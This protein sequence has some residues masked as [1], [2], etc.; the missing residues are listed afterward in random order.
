MKGN[1][2]D[3]NPKDGIGIKKVPFSLIP[4]N[5]LG[6][7]GLS[8]LEGS[9]KYGSNNW[10]CAGVRASVYIDALRRHLASWWNGQDI[11]PDSG[12]SHIVKAIACLIILRDSM[13]IGNW[14]DDRP[15]KSEKDFIKELNKQ[16]ELLIEKYP[17]AV[18][19]YTEKN[20]NA[21]R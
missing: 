12:L 19:P 9:L 1:V 16:A 21:P 7:V 15:P 8:F 10:K 6:E 14:T 13:L 5:V 3:T 17:N 18:K 2:K 20:K 4:E 11:D